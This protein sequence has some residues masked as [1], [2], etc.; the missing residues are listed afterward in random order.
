[1]AVPDDPNSFVLPN[2]S[3][4][5]VL[6]ISQILEVCIFMHSL[7]GR[8]INTIPSAILPVTV[9][10]I[11]GNGD[12]G[13]YVASQ[14]CSRTQGIQGRLI[15]PEEMRCDDVGNCS[16][17]S[18]TRS[19]RGGERQGL[20]AVGNKDNGLHGDLLGV[21]GNVGHVERQHDNVRAEEELGH[22]ERRQPTAHRRDGQRI[23]KYRGD[24][25][26]QLAQDDDG[27]A[28][29]QPRPSPR[30]VPDAAVAQVR[31]DGG[32]DALDHG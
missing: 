25:A 10:C 29:L 12:D 24:H 11:H 28:A 23:Q 1:M 5:D 22:P 21:P 3:E 26:H 9:Q 13:K 30:Q 14:N 19:G 27:H 15:V 6:T 20:T 32:D 17:S 2:V 8:G 18:V 16:E 4:V 7:S 31:R